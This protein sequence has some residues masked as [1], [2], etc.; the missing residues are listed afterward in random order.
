MVSMP[1][2]ASEHARV[3]RHPERASYDP[4]A[5]HAVLDAGFLGHLGYVVD[6]RPVVVPVLYGRDGDVVYLHGSTG[7]RAMRNAGGGTPVCLTVTHLDALVLARSA[8]HS[9][10]NYRSAVVHGEAVPVEGAAKV[11]A[12]RVVTEQ[13]LPGRWVHVRPPTAKELASVAVLA[14]PLDEAAVKMRTG[15][16][17]DDEADLGL[18]VWA[19]VLPLHQVAGAPVPAAGLPRGLAVPEHVT[20]WRQLT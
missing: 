16:P 14:L 11:G 1:P 19:G 3:R 15:G 7:S 2:P 5:L 10:A 20:S 13:S 6:G 18:P 12:L 17:G 8:T 9:S 4:G